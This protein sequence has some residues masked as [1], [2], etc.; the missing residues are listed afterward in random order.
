M[1]T[2]SLNWG[3]ILFFYLISVGV[4]IVIFWYGQNIVIKECL[5]NSTQNSLRKVI[6]WIV[7]KIPWQEDAIVKVG[8]YWDVSFLQNNVQKTQKAGN[9]K[10]LL[11]FYSKCSKLALFTSRHFKTLLMM[12][13]V[14]RET[15]CWV[16]RHP[17]LYL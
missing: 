3:C 15:C 9:D 10:E 8:K 14:A 13:P 11:S 1:S 7:T 6:H 12:L 2:V 5:A 16:K 4:L 17:I